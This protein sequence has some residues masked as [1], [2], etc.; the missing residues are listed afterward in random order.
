MTSA[1]FGAENWSDSP[2]KRPSKSAEEAEGAGRGRPGEMLSAVR[3]LL[4][5]LGVL[6]SD[7]LTAS[8]VSI[9]SSRTS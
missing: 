9:A 3:A 2:T 6:S 1:S 5:R 4:A 8:T 7:I